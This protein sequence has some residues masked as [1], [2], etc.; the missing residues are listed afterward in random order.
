MKKTRIAFYKGQKS[1]NPSALFGDWLI[2][3][4]TKHFASHV[5][6]IEIHGPAPWGTSVKGKPYVGPLAKMWSSSLRDGGVRGKTLTLVPE[7]WV[8]VEIDGD[9]AAALAYIQE[10]VG[11]P[12]GW[13]DL[14]SFLLPF[15]FNTKW[16]FC[17]EI[18]AA[19]FGLPK[20]WKTSP[21][22][23]YDW[24]KAQPGFRIV[25]D[26]ELYKNWQA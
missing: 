24:A 16:L 7:R 9:S 11:T 8:V 12:Y 23:L 1:Q 15:N 3:L 5:E 21:G 20:P 10:R 19:A 25:P 6:L 17:S 13:P 2:C 18:I 14:F 22:D 26:D 4:V